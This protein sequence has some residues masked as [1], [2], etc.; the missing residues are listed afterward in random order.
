MDPGAAINK[1]G[2]DR[3]VSRS[4]LQTALGKRTYYALSAV[5]RPAAVD[6]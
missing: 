1:W 3:V 4:M 5:V 2:R 6:D